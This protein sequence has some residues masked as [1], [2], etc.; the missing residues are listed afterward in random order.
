MWCSY[1]I[2]PPLF[3]TGV[4]IYDEATCT[5]HVY[6]AFDAASA[7][8]VAGTCTWCSVSGYCTMDSC[9][10][11]HDSSTCPTNGSGCYWSSNRGMCVTDICSSVWDEDTCWAT[12]AQWDIDHDGSGTTSTCSWD[13]AMHMQGYVRVSSVAVRAHPFSLS[14]VHVHSRSVSSF[15]T[16]RSLQR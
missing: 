12:L 14:L 5:A 2:S 4:N 15:E 13:G 7:D 16:Y 3:P 1:R 11:N 6:S 8:Y 10:Q 9:M